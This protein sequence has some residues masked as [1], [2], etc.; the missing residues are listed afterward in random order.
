M[1]IQ[2]LRI[3][4]LQDTIRVAATVIWED[5]ERPT[6]EIFIATPKEFA[7]YLHPNPDSYLVGCMFPAIDHGEKRIKLEGAVCPE[8]IEGI[9]TAIEWFRQWYRPNWGTPRIE[10]DVRSRPLAHPVFRSASSFLSGGIDSLAMLR[11]N[12]L[13]YPETH[14]MFIKHCFLVYGFGMGGSRI[15]YDKQ[16]EAFMETAT[17]L[18][19]VARDA[20]VTLVPIYTNL[21]HLDDNL[22]FWNYVFHGAFLAAVAHSLLP[23]VHTMSIAASDAIT[24]ISPWGSHPLIDP[25]FSSAD[26]KIRHDGIT[27]SR[28]A[29]VKLVG[30]WDV[31]L[32]NLHVCSH[33]YKSMQTSPRV[34]NCGKCEKCVR[35]M[36]ELLAVGLLNKSTGIFP[37]TEL[38]KQLLIKAMRGIGSE[39]AYYRELVLPLRAQGR[40][41]LVRPIKKTI[42]L[43]QIKRAI[44]RLCPK[45]FEPP[46]RSKWHLWRTRK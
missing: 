32:R 11:A 12:H 19:D 45:L 35:T 31:A 5:S 43:S 29:K 3:E 23:L 28:L 27:Y 14:P 46:W 42:L 8:L 21:R 40:D 2:N 22:R 38:S 41:D 4:S 39:E 30:E 24:D 13:T 7:G 10:S 15:D 33:I 36:A 34:L 20:K 37:S 44:K 17:G 1:K 6:Q 16:T 25:N 26:L 18:G 9:N